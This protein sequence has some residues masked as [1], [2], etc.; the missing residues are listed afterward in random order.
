MSVQNQRLVDVDGIVAR[1]KALLLTPAA[2]WARIDE[3]PA[4]V[5]GLYTGYIMMLAAI[6]PVC[7]ALGGLAFGYGFSFI[8]YQPLL[9]PVLVA[10]VVEYAL[11]LVGVYVI[12]L[13][14]DA[15]APNFDAQKNPIQA[16]KVAVYSS[17][18]AWVAGVFW[19]IPNLAPI[20]GLLGL[21]SFYLLY[22]GLPRLM[23]V[24]E[25]KALGYTVATVGVVVLGYLIMVVIAGSV[26]G[27]IATLGMSPRNGGTVT[28]DLPSFQH[29]ATNNPPNAARQSGDVAQGKSDS[30]PGKGVSAE[31]L[32]TLLP[33]IL[34][35]GFTRTECRTGSVLGGPH[36]EAVYTNGNKHMTLGVTDISAAAAV[37]AVTS[38]F[39][40]ESELVTPSGFEK[41]GKVDGRMTIQKWDN[42]T[43]HGRYSVLV[44]NRFILNA[45][46]DVGSFYDL[47]SAV[48]TVGPNQVARLK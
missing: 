43:R 44:D 34:P 19:I 36:A 5:G 31:V 46:G 39:G 38:G 20:G 8:S 2:E 26:I 12:G 37:A 11:S 47:Q 23:K 48:G 25:A 9:G 3:E 4:S 24:P 32:A 15:L 1:I 10:A 28:F 41:I 27:T 33:E 40:L 42:N 30:Q 35:D 45:E 13:I 14:I 29:V 22:L 17:T 7:A 18:A 21:Y 6:R 16:F